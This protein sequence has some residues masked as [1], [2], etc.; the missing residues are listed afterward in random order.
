MITR[1][2]LFPCCRP[3][4]LPTEWLELGVCLTL[5]DRQK[6]HDLP[7]SSVASHPRLRC[8]SVGAHLQAD[9]TLTFLQLLLWEISLVLLCFPKK[10]THT[11]WK[12]AKELPIYQLQTSVLVL[13]S[14]TCFHATL[15]VN[16]HHNAFLFCKH[17]FALIKKHKQSKNVSSYVFKG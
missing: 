9:D 4:G 15:L 1:V 13:Q 8:S 16:K 2:R 11:C 7:R 6:S 3:H 5:S 17:F 14:E 12:Q 10:D